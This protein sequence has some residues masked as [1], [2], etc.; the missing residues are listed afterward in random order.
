MLDGESGEGLTAEV[1]ELG[2]RLF[3]SASRSRNLAFSAVA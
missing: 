2:D 1:R 3:R